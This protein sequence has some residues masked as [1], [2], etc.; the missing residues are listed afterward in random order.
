MFNDFAF[1]DEVQLA[2]VNSINWARVL[3]QVV[4]YVSSALAL[5]RA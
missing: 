4:Y 1:R 5:G 3:A 2:G